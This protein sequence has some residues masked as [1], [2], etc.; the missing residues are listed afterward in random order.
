[1]NKSSVLVHSSTT[2]VLHQVGSCE[3][4]KVDGIILGGVVVDGE[5]E[6][7]MLGRRLVHLAERDA[8]LRLDVQQCRAH[9]LLLRFR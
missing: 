3:K 8:R 2:F 1:M 7:G 6:V 5:E 9:Q 4:C